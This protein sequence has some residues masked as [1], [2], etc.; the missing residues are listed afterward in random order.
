MN[1]DVVIV[2]AGPAGLCLAR[3]LAGTGLSI[4]L[5]E[6]RDEASL[7]EPEFDGREI[8]LTHHSVHLLRELG[9]WARIP[10]GDIHELKDALVMNGSGQSGMSLDHGDGN[11]PQLGFL[12]ANQMIRKAAFAAIA[13]QDGLT[14]ACGQPVRG[15]EPGVDRSRICLGDGRVLAARL[16]VAADSRFSTMRRAMGIGADSH[17]FGKS[18]L[19]CRMHHEAPHGQVAWEWFGHGQT[20]ARLP[21]VEHESSV[22]L[23]LPPQVMQDLANAPEAEFAAAIEA[24]FQ[25]RLGRM[26][27]TSTRHVYPLVGVYARR[28]TAARFAL[29][30]DAAVGMHP[31]TAHGFNLGLLGQDLLAGVVRRG[32]DG[33]QDIGS[34]A[35]LRPYDRGLRRASR[36]LYLATGAI[37]GLFTDDSHAARALRGLVLSAGTRLPAVR[38]ALVHSV[39]HAGSSRAATYPLLG[40]LRTLLP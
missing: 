38:R 32:L 34:P 17:D 40:M 2:G 27:L 31:V 29:V 21:L 18:M 23:T 13:A 22:V 30:G 12:V 25:H 6:V 5:L 3:S 11:R 4:A 26:E 10:A 1:V 16:V 7:A 24:R 33:R 8:A 14:L 9:I 19:V 28:F 39:T 35:L 20:L 15:I 37:V 36:P